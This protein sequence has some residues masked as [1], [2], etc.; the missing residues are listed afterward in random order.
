MKVTES[1]I[2]SVKPY[3]RN[4][5]KNDAA[6]DGVAESIRQFGFRQPIVVDGAGV[7]VVGHT[8]WKAAK[9]LGLK[10][11]PVHVAADLTPAQARAYR[12]ADNKTNELAEWDMEALAAELDGLKVDGFD[13]DAPFFNPKTIEETEAGAVKTSEKTETLTP[14]K[15]LHVLLSMTA[16]QGIDLLPEIAK[17]AI[18][19]NLEIHHAGN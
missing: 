17:F 3:D 13:I 4:P 5:R 18:A 6:V 11:V 19:H 14:I 9:K 16:D 2:D 8:R 12:I 15:K 7:I 1:P 10:A